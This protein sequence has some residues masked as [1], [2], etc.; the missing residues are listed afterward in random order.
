MKILF[1][2]NKLPLSKLI[3]DVLQEP[4]SH[5]SLDFGPFVVHSDLRGVHLQWARKYKMNVEVVFQLKKL[6]PEDDIKHLDSLLMDYEHALY[7]FGALLFLGLS[8]TLRKYLKLPLPKSNLWQSSGMFLCT[9]WV[10]K[11]VDGAEDSMITPY[12]LYLKLRNT[13]NWIEVN[14]Q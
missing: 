13:D 3:Q 8:F 11:Y 10:N 5:V 1:I 7:D 2:R 6:A 9:E 12:Q 4:V 14:E